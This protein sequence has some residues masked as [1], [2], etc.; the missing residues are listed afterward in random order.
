MFRFNNVPFELLRYHHEY[1][2][3]KKEIV[4]KEHYEIEMNVS[5][6]RD[7]RYFDGWK[8]DMEKSGGPLFTMGSHYFDLL[9]DLFGPEAEAHM[10]SFDGK[11]GQGFV[12]GDNYD[13]RWRVSVAAKI[14]E[15][16]KREFIVNGYAVNFSQKE[17][18]AE[19]NLHRFVY[20]DLSQ[21]RGVVPDQV[22][23]S[24]ELIE[25]L[26]GSVKK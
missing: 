15:P 14:D 21:G 25:K 12:K 20:E 1:Q 8:G 2:R 17:N 7:R 24:I 23:P 6:Y 22:L 3:L 19:E 11:T 10:E 5:V 13:C 9:L 16:W 4:R 18:L 26:Y